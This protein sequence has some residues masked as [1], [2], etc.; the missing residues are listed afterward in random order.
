MTT[1]QIS[2]EALKYFEE[3]R[4]KALLE[5]AMHNLLLDL[6]DDPLE[7]LQKSFS[8]PTPLRIMFSGGPG[9]GKGTQ[10]ELLAK[11]YN[12]LAINARKLLIREF[13]E[14]TEMG[15]RIEAYL[16]KAALVPDE[17]Y[18]EL[19]IREVRRAEKDYQGWVLD[20]FPQTRAHAIS[21]QNAGISPQKFFYLSI[22]EEVAAK[23]CL[24]RKER[25]FESERNSLLNSL[26]LND[27]PEGIAARLKHFSARKD[28]L[29][30]CY[31]PFFVRIAGSKSIEDV[32]NEI[33]E[34]IDNLDIAH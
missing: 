12:L 6:P 24:N 26:K 11:K 22:P 3:K 5:E 30:D 20:G 29:L 9:S 32:N 28:E 18:V 8:A 13:D 33:C 25:C 31:Q 27:T 1:G 16:R 4:I 19:I 15:H 23:R 10:S 21:L 17:I 14:G 7:Y 2:E 34:Q